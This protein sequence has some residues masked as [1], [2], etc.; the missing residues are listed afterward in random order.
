MKKISINLSPQKENITSVILQRLGSYTFQMGVL[1]ALILILVLFLQVFIFGQA[2][3]YNDYSK[4]WKNWGEKDKLV[5]KIK[6]D[7][8]RLKEEKRKIEE[9]ATPEYDTVLILSNIFSSLPKNVWFE[10]LN[11]EKGIINLKGYV[12]KWGED[13]LISLDGFINSLREKEYFSLNFNQINIK[14]S[15]KAIFNGLETVKFTIECKK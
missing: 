7:I 4:K 5:K 14:E 1:A 2:Y 8:F 15:H 3:K 12:L 10:E 11:C 9:I 13:Y 6:K